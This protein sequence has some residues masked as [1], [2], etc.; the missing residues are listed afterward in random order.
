M[1]PTVWLVLKRATMRVPSASLS[2]IVV[3]GKESFTDSP[4]SPELVLGL[5]ELEAALDSAT[6]G[7]SDEDHSPKVLPTPWNGLG[8]PVGACV[9]QVPFSLV[10]ILKRNNRIGFR[11]DIPDNFLYA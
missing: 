5:A 9:H 2:C 8:G 4:D 3:E 11:I 10:S 6:R 7:V 1:C